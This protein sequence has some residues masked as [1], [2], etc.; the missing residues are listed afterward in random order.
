MT[1]DSE[2][3]DEEAPLRLSCEKLG[4]EDEPGRP[5][6]F[7]VL[8]FLL[9]ENCKCLHTFVLLAFFC[10]ILYPLYKYCVP[11]LF[12]EILVTACL[13]P[14]FNALNIPLW[15]SIVLLIYGGYTLHWG[16]F[17]INWM[18]RAHSGA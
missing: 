16:D 17:Q 13:C 4:V 8:S 9:S 11:C 7:R 14:Y 2:A 15:A 3:T 6:W 10:V 12:I 18:S 1:S 5:M